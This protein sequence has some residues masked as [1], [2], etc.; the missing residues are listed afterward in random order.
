MVALGGPPSLVVISRRVFGDSP[1][2]GV[3][4]LL[5]MILSSSPHIGLQPTATRCDAQRRG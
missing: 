3:Q 4:T 2:I 5:Q 1:A